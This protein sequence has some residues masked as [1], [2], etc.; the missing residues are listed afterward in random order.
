MADPI[1]RLAAAIVL[2]AVRDAQEDG[3]PDLAAP[4]RRWLAC[5]GVDLAEVL[6]IPP[7]RIEAWLRKLP[8]LTYEQLPLFE[9]RD[10]IE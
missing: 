6:D 1:R 7:E 2:Q 9:D 3:D 10:A 4:A 5:A 8:S